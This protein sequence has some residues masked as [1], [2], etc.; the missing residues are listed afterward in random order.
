VNGQA[1]IVA[2]AEEFEPKHH[3]R[4]GIISQTTQPIEKLR[5]WCA[6]W[7]RLRAIALI[8][9]ILSATAIRQNRPCR[10]RSRAT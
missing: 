10:W 3:A 2:G 5:S 6:G 1:I 4:L 9:T 7:C 8:N